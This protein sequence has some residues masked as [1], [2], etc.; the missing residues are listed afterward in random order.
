MACHLPATAAAMNDPSVSNIREQAIAFATTARQQV[1]ATARREIEA[2]RLAI[3]KELASLDE[4]LSSG[5][6]QSA[7]DPAV[8]QLCEAAKTT[9]AFTQAQL[10]DEIQNRQAIVA[11]LAATNEKLAQA[12]SEIERLRAEYQRAQARV[13]TLEQ[14]LLARSAGPVEI[15]G[16]VLDQIAQ[17]LNALGESSTG[18]DVLTTLVD[19]FAQRFS[20]VVLCSVDALG[21]TVW[22]SRGFNPPIERKTVI[23]V[24][25]E[26]PL[27]RAAES[28]HPVS[29][30]ETIGLVGSPVRYAIA[31]PIVAKGRGMAML[32]A[33][34]LPGAPVEWDDRIA[35][36]LAEI[37]AHYV[38]SRLQVKPS[39]DTFE[40]EAHPKQRQAK[41]VKMHDGTTVVLDDSEGT[42][43]D[44][45][46]LGAQVLSRRA[47]RPNSAVRLVLDTHAGGVACSAR[48]V[49]VIV[50]QQPTTQSAL[51]RAGVQFTNVQHGD[52]NGYLEFFDSAIR[53]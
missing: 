1:V 39:A 27:A 21:F 3:T 19:L 29:S 17:A 8:E 52:L 14:Q 6:S 16:G 45:S 5:A 12:A 28:W 2:L 37:L 26:S 42:L 41:R 38:K 22:R 10:D 53:H 51:Y 33:E 49:L 31:L 48:V 40:P 36:Q 47:M 20:R 30:N 44:L 43:I 24:V 18:T 50:E 13:Q 11:E 46:S 15:I 32:Y 34:N 23:R 4:A 35:G 9:L 7:T 25:P